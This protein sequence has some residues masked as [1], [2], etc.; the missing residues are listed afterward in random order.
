MLIHSSVSHMALALQ[1]LA[2]ELREME[3]PHEKT[4]SCG[5]CPMALQPG[6]DRATS[7]RHWFDPDVKCCTYHPLLYNFQVGRALRR[8]DVGSE[9]IRQRIGWKRGVQA[10]G[11]AP[12]KSWSKRYHANALETF[13]RD[14]SLTCPYWQAGELN[15]TIWKDRNAIC[16]T[17]YCK[18]E[19]AGRGWALW[20]GVNR[21]TNQVERVLAY[22]VASQVTPPKKESASIRDWVRYFVECANVADRVTGE[23]LAAMSS[24]ETDERRDELRRA[25]EHYNTP[26][27]L[28][29]LLGASVGSVVYIPSG[30][31]RLV[32]YSY[33]NAMDFSSTIFLFLS[34]LDGKRTWQTALA[35]AR[36]EAGED[37]LSEDEIARMWHLGILD[38][39]DVDD[40]GKNRMK[41]RSVTMGEKDAFKFNLE[42]AS[43]EAFGRDDDDEDDEL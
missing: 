25:H 31:V 33:Y 10:L 16:R 12:P 39:P 19:N 6:E 11:I 38:H 30:R 8:D 41:I 34:R 40:D 2:P 13:G 32:G 17:W 21:L 22:H 28:P 20:Q 29:D 26:R 42:G 43:L 23:E 5:S 15:C 18:H 37:I 24:A 14:P 9:K 7:E 35:E 4:S 1:V 3:L 27:P 36:A